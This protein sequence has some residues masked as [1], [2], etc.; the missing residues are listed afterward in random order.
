MSKTLVLCIDRDNDFGEKAGIRSPI[1]GRESNLSAANSLMLADAE[2]SD[3]N[4]LFSAIST[5]DSLVKSGELMK[6]SLN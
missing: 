3:S 1:I 2:D 6:S 4:A 5:Y